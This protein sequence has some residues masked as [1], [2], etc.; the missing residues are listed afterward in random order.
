MSNPCSKKYWDGYSALSTEIRP[1]SI[2]NTRDT[3]TPIFAA[4]VAAYPE[5]ARLGWK[6]FIYLPF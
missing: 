3:P 5:T 1:K 4:K 6:A 2:K